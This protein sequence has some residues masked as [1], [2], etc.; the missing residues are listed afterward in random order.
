MGKVVAYFVAVSISAE[1]GM[2]MS[3]NAATTWLDFPLF[4]GPRSAHASAAPSPEMIKQRETRVIEA[5]KKEGTLVY[6]S[7]TAA[8]DMEQV[9][10]KFREKYPFVKT[11][12]WR[13]DNVSRQQKLLS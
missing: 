11:D 6:W 10:S 12:H 8:A 13:S 7:S 9:L 5:A 3:L 1:L 4:L 2:T